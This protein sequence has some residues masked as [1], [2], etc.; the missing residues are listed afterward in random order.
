MIRGLQ[1]LT[2]LLVCALVLA[3]FLGGW[4]WLAIAALVFFVGVW[5]LVEDFQR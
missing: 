2:M 4:A 1:T 5:A 3:L